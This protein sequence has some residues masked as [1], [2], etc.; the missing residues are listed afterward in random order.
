MF[1]VVNETIRLT[2]HS[3]VES[4]KAIKFVIRFGYPSNKSHSLL[5]RSSYVQVTA[6]ECMC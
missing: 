5:C 6:G 1:A 4:S 3:I 2:I